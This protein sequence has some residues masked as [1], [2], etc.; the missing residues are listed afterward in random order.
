MANPS[1]S[2]SGALV[3]DPRANMATLVADMLRVLLA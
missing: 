1:A 3:I 2:R